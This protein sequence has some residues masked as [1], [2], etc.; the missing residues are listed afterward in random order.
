MTDQAWNAANMAR[1][2]RGRDRVE[3]ARQLLVGSKTLE[4]SLPRPPASGRNPPNR[5]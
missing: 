4:P 3:D 5:D 1:V 2:A